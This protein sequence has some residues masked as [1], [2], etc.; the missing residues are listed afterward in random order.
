MYDWPEVRWAHDALWSAIAGRLRAAGVEAP[1]TLDRS[2][3]PDDIWAD[4]GLILSQTCGYPY[5]TRLRSQVRLVG[6]PIY[7]VEGCDGPLYSSAIVVRRGESGVSLSDF[8][9]RPFAFNGRESLSGYVAPRVAM[10]EAGLDPKSFLWNET[11]SHRASV[12]AVAD[13]LSDIASIDAVCWALAKEHEPKA[14]R[15]LKPIAWTPKRPGLPFVTA[16]AR[17][18]ST[19]E[20]LRVAIEDALSG[21]DTQAARAALHISGIGI[22]E[23]INYLAIAAL[24]AE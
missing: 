19:L 15:R 5:A 7:D 3:S 22:I 20:R 18:G 13:G 11:T 6:T 24:S 23:E 21:A 4:D 2:R 12:R 16:R 17:T 9:G 10:R 1:A 8:L 14:A